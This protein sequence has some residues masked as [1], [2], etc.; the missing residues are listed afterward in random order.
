MFKTRLENFLFF[1]FATYIFRILLISFVFLWDPHQDR[2]WWHPGSSSTNTRGSGSH[3]APGVAPPQKVDCV[4][5]S[6]LC[7]QSGPLYEEQLKTRIVLSNESQ[8]TRNSSWRKKAGI[9][10]YIIKL[11][12]RSCSQYLEIKYYVD[13]LRASTELYELIFMIL[14]QWQQF[15]GFWIFPSSLIWVGLDQ[16]GWRYN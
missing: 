16:T 1:C 13:F 11:R 7:N 10:Y 8:V 4:R 12:V 2:G 6:K 5:G 9:E 15:S 3:P 14:I